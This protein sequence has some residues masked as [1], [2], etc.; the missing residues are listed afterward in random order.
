MSEPYYPEP[1]PVPHS[2]GCLCAMCSAEVLSTPATYQLACCDGIIRLF[3]NKD[4]AE[5]Y[6]E[7]NPELVKR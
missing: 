3:C 1:S 2:T 6:A 4:H 7:L 5:L